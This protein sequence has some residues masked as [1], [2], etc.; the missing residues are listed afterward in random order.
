MFQYTDIFESPC[1]ET[2]RLKNLCVLYMEIFESPCIETRRLEYMNR[3][4]YKT[5]MF[6]YM[7]IFES[8]CIETGRFKNLRVN[9]RVLYMEIFTL[10][11]YNSAKKQQMTEIF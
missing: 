6:Q 7:E 1:I 10:K 2:Q 8:P 3:L 11:A 4:P 9:L 5:S